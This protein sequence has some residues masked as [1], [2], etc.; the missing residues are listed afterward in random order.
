MKS[1]NKLLAAGK[2]LA[3]I[4]TRLAEQKALLEQLRAIMPLSMAE[5]C[6][7]AVHNR[8]GILVL[9]ADSPAWASRLRYLSTKLSQKLRQ[10]GYPVTRIQVK[11][12]ILNNPPIQQKIMRRANTLSLSNAKILNSIAESVDDEKLSTALMRLSRHGLD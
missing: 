5:H 3:T 4:D 2:T 7:W 9:M 12:T 6:I 1:I 8:N 10:I 11:V